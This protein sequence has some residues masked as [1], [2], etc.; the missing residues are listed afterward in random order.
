MYRRSSPGLGALLFCLLGS[1]CDYSRLLLRGCLSKSRTPYSPRKMIGPR[2]FSFSDAEVVLPFAWIN[3]RIV[4]LHAAPPAVL[5][6]IRF[7]TMSR[8]MTETESTATFVGH[9]VPVDSAGDLPDLDVG[10]L[11][12]PEGQ[13]F[14]HYHVSLLCSSKRPRCEWHLHL[15]CHLFTEEVVDRLFDFHILRGWFN[16]LYFHLGARDQATDRSTITNYV[17]KGRIELPSVLR[18]TLNL[19]QEILRAGLPDALNSHAQLLQGWPA[20]WGPLLSRR[21]SPFRRAS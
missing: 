12:E 20:S 7:S 21:S 6:P 17:L 9:H 2:L 11:Q 4:S 5:N 16:I 10:R 1:S 13:R 14:L 15:R 8:H 3:Y 18:S 19:Y